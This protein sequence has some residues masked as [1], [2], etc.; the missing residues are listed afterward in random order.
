MKRSELYKKVWSMPIVRLA[1]ELGISD[2]GL[3]KACRRHAIPVPPRGYWAKLKA[4][5][6]PSMLPLPAPELDVIVHF[7][8]SDPEELARQRALAQHR[9]ELL[10]ARAVEA[11]KLPPI[12]FATSLEGAHPL[13]KATQRY[14]E[15]MP[16]L[17][18][19]SQRRGGSNWRTDNLQDR[20]PPEQ[21]GRYSLLD[22]DCLDICASLEAMNWVLLFHATLLRGLLHGGM[23]VVRREGHRD[24]ASGRADGPAIEMRLKD[25]VL[26]FKFSEGYRRVRLTPEEFEVKRK[27]S[28][29][30][31]EYEMR[32]SG[33]FTFSIEGTEFHARKAWQGNKE[34]MEGQVNE[35]IRTAFHL[36]L[37]QPQLR[38][39]REAR[40]ANSRR[41]EE[42][43]A[44]QRRRRE[45]RAE[46]LKQAFLMME[47]DA[48]VRQLELFL[49]RLSQT[50]S[51]LSPPYDQ[52]ARVWVD[53]VRGE[54][55]VSNPVDEILR[56]C[57][58]V[59]SWA[60]WPPAWWPD[61]SSST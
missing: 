51:E 16:R 8:T 38:S 55:S 12:E 24:R 36:A 15:R 30:A 58:T 44:Q 40:E 17:I 42:I 7:A 53:V 48:R 20:L 22:R 28:P 2:V 23:T 11:T 45:A 43:R 25:E 21:H 60:S 27:D 29:W 34:R 10:Q 47:A 59:P 52:R 33:N 49:D 32:P 50:C 6:T 19:R 9:A 54:L 5:Q 4:G 46:Q 1:K 14:C 41:E 37:S 13:V 31:R 61:D 39:E 56:K 18:E 57:L 3:A 26:T 35:I